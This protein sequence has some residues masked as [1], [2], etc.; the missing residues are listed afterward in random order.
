MLIL[1][2]GAFILSRGMLVL[3]RGAFILSPGAFAPS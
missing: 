1:L 2:G 3:L